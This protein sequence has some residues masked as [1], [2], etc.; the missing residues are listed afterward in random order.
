MLQS[1]N[2]NELSHFLQMLTNAPQ[3]GTAVTSTHT[4]LTR[5]QVSSVFVMEDTLEMVLNAFVSLLVYL[6]RGCHVAEDVLRL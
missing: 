5:T 3:E 6:G 1:V 2:N 4:V